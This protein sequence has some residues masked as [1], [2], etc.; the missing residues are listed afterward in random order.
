MNTA[1]NRLR[2]FEKLEQN[3][4]DIGIESAVAR[5]IAVEVQDATKHATEALQVIR[6]T[7]GDVHG[8]KPTYTRIVYDTIKWSSAIRGLLEGE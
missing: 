7:S 4:I 8:T 2:V 3:L 1:L 5:K 6:R